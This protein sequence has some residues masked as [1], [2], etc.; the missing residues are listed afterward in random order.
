LIG[1]EAGDEHMP[2]MIGPVFAG[3][4]G[5]HPFGSGCIH[6]PEQKQFHSGGAF[7]EDTEI[8]PSRINCG[9]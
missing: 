8:D 5:N 1:F 3:I 7:G 6:F 4:E 2:V 9:S